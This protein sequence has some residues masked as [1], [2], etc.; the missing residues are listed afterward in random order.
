MLLNSQVLVLNRLWQAVNICSARRA[1]ALVYAGHAQVVATDGVNNFLTHD[2]NSWRDFSAQSPEPEMVTTI[3]WKIRV[4]RVIVLLLF[5]RLP[6]KEV[7]FTR[8]NVFERDK[9]TCQYCGHVFERSDLNLD[10]V[11]P[12]DRGGLTTW[13]NVVCSCIGCNTRKGNRLPHEAHMTLI[14]KPKRPK[15][16]PF[17]QVTFTTQQH[18]SW[19]HF[20][21]LAYW[22]VELSD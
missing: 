1:F 17:V 12:R 14:R 20:V 2:F 16:R 13:E 21:D 4:P 18:E 8:H 5:D 19:R 15:W 11:L 7:K 10:H 3:S 6:K 22:N 9:N